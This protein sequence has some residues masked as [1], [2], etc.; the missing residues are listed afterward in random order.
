MTATVSLV[1]IIQGKI[2]C[3]RGTVKKFDQHASIFHSGSNFTG[4]S[5]MI[6]QTTVGLFLPKIAL[7]SN[8]L[9]HQYL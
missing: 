8:I 6:F 4:F 9:S 2:R 1:T 7:A 5:K 3:N